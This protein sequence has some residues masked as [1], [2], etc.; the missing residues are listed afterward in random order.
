MRLDNK[1]ASGTGAAGVIGREI[2]LAASSS[3]M[4]ATSIREPSIVEALC[5]C[6]LGDRTAPLAGD[7]PPRSVAELMRQAPG[8]AGARS[9]IEQGLGVLDTA[10]MG[11]TGLGFA[12]LEQPRQLAALFRLEAGGP[13]LSQERAEV[14][15]DTFLTLAAQAYLQ[16]D[17]FAQH[18][19]EPQAS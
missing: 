17:G 9:L 18:H 4:P 12:Q 14:F 2:A 5:N 10:V 6:I 3:L 15:I 8:A 1:V 11:D 16:N 19:D 13:A 7:W